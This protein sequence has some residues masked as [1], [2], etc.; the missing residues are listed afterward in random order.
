MLKINLIK[1]TYK[2]FVFVAALIFSS[3]ASAQSL[4]NDMQSCQALIEFVEQ[5]LSSPPASYDKTKVTNILEGLGAYN[6]HIQETIVTPGLLQFNQGDKAKAQNMQQQVD[7]YKKTLI[8][9][10]AK[11]FPEN[12]MYTDYAVSLNNCTKKAVPEGEALEQLK[13]ALNT[14]VALAR[15]H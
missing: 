6:T 15:S 7:A 13:V 3:F 8:A 10:F 4:I 9:N 12:R 2:P 1:Q 5:R 14:M 11:R